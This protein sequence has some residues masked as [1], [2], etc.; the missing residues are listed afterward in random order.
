MKQDIKK[1]LVVDD[2][3]KILEVIKS[4][5]ES[6][7]YTVFTAENGKQAFDIFERENI[8]LVILDLMLPGTI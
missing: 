5:L 2:E 6:K 1:V 3:V 8:S 7:G 4:F